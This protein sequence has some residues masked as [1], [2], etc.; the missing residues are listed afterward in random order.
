M[1][2]LNSSSVLYNQLVDGAVDVLLLK[3]ECGKR[4]FCKL[5]VFWY[6]VLPC[7]FIQP[8]FGEIKQVFTLIE[9]IYTVLLVE[10]EVF[11]PCRLSDIFCLIFQLLHVVSACLWKCQPVLLYAFYLPV[12]LSCQ[13]LTEYLLNVLP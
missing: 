10:L 8:V 12:H 11:N 2:Y 4:P 7:Q 3:Q 1:S 6:P 13:Y 5:P 9:T